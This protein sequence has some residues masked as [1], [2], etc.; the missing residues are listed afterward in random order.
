MNRDEELEKS[1][2]GRLVMY[3]SEIGTALEIGLR[4]EHFSEK[5]FEEVFE[6][7]EKKYLENSNFN[8]TELDIDMEYL[9]DLSDACNIINI[10]R[11][12]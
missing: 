4:A 5:D 10:E 12:V 6:K 9:S 7:M 3:Q 11:A 8:I 2:L 1:L